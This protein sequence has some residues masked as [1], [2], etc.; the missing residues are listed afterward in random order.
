MINTLKEIGETHDLTIAQTAM[1]W[2]VTKGVLP[3]IGV[4]SAKH[5]D[6]AAKVVATT[7]TAS[8]MKKLETVAD[9]TGVNTIGSWEQDMR[10]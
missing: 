7:L 3:I 6:D 10:E 8:E 1:S 4:T 5:V 2:A 9:K